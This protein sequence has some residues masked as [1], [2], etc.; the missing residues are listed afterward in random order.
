[1]DGWMDGPV[2]L[3]EERGGSNN[4]ALYGQPVQIRVDTGQ[5]VS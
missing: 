5:G 1:M 3:V 2:E 4:T